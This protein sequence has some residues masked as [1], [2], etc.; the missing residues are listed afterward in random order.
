M[1]KICNIKQNLNEN[2][3]NIALNLGLKSPFVHCPVNTLSTCAL[4]YH[5]GLSFNFEEITKK[6]FFEFNTNLENLQKDTVLKMQDLDSKNSLK[7]QDIQI[8]N[9][10]HEKFI[11]LTQVHHSSEKFTLFSSYK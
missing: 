3:R 2:F 8:K 9:E 5:A 11:I 7:D 1:K 4:Q 6:I 10:Y